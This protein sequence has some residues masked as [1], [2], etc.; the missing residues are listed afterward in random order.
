MRNLARV[1]AFDVQEE[2]PNRSLLTIYLAFD[3]PRPRNLLKRVAWWLFR[4]TFPGFVHDVVWN[5]AL[6]KL[7]Y[8][9]ERDGGQTH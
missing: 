6:C 9:V 8:D 1:L 5:H 4:L 3:F 7:K 2:G